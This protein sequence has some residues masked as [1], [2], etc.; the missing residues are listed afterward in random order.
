MEPGHNI[1]T[2]NISKNRILLMNGS[3]DL[4]SEECRASCQFAL[5]AAYLNSGADS[6]MK[7]LF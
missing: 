7:L 3:H 6:I 4:S 5:N 1:R 2:S